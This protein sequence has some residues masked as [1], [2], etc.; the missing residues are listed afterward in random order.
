MK[1]MI[2]ILI[3]AILITI[4]YFFYTTEFW[5]PKGSYV[6]VNQPSVE[7]LRNKLEIVKEELRESGVYRCCIQ[8]DCSWCAIYMGRCICADL[9]VVEGREQSCPECAAAWN[10]KLGKIPGV[11]PDAVEVIT[12]GVYGF[13]N[14]DND[15][16]PY[17]NEDYQG[18]DDFENVVPPKKNT[19]DKEL[20]K[21]E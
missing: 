20:H 12:F 1:K 3:P 10:R 21:N 18:I 16:Y 9:I 13:E 7:E 17:L 6:E 11:D 19:S 4:G 5:E 14:E 2:Y 8:N 15:N